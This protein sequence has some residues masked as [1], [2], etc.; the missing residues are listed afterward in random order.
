M[1]LM[2]HTASS[3]SCRVTHMSHICHTHVTHMSHTATTCY[4]WVVSK[5]V[6]R[7]GKEGWMPVLF[8]LLQP[9]VSAAALGRAVRHKLHTTHTPPS[10]AAA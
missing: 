3:R 7:G 4:M 10:S 1:G 2:F 5:C 8:L 9:T 6:H